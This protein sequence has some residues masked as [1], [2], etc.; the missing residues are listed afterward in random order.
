MVRT[1]GCRI[2]P[3]AIATPMPNPNSADIIWDQDGRPLSRLF[4]D[5]YFSELTPVEQ[6]RTVFLTPSELTTRWQQLLPGQAFTIAETG[7]GSGLNFLNAWQS[8]QTHAPAMATLN[9]ISAEKYPLLRHDLQRILRL[10]P[11]FSSMAEQLADQYPAVDARGF[12]RLRF[13]NVHL[14]LIFSDAVDGLG[15][16]LPISTQGPYLAAKDCGWAPYTDAPTHVDAW[17]LDGFDPL[18]NPQMWRAELF[19]IIS[20][21]SRPGT[22]IATSTASDTVALDLQ[23]VGFSAQQGLTRCGG[24]QRLFGHKLAPQ[25]SAR[26]R[27][28]SPSDTSP[29]NTFNH[30]RQA[31]PRPAPSWHLCS[32][33]LPPPKQ[34]AIIGA[35]LAG[36]QSAYA[37][38]QKGFKVTLIDKA[39]MATGA[40][41]NPQGVLYSKLSSSAGALAEFNIAALT[42]AL[43]FYKREGLFARCGDP[44]GVLQLPESA[45]K[46]EQQRSVASLFAQSPELVQWLDGANAS[47]AAG[48]TIAT[49]ALWLP[50]AGWLDPPLLC[51]TLS[52]HANIHIV[53]HRNVDRLER[54]NGQWQLTDEHGALIT[55]AEAVVIAC[56]ESARR[57]EQCSRLPIKAIRGQVSWAAA[58]DESGPL[59]AVLC[60]EGYVAPAR[61]GVHC[62]GASFNLTSRSTE[63]RWDEHHSNLNQVGKLSSAMT[64]LRVDEL[65]AGRASMR[66]TTPDYL[67]LIGPVAHQMAMGERFSVYRQNA[68][69]TVDAPGDYWPG[70]FINVGHGSKGLTY[71]PLCA[72]LLACMITNQPLPLSRKSI[73]HLHS[74]RFLIR[75]LARGRLKA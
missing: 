50:N 2:W 52:E 43:R 58:T 44:C 57:F 70:L 27:S 46:V 54:Q 24:R 41:G 21:L 67:P 59:K 68:K 6:S 36:C 31:K 28:T 22:T 34:I 14:T 69:A 64:S 20:R 33:T 10:W 39:E 23:K 74:A 63:N 40:S 37:L 16:C 71:T 26:E 55:T 11:E 42:Y 62:I 9:Y 60:G 29:P 17:F 8:W 48:V 12:H 45:A 7:F 75:D 72:E 4:N 15:Q 49:G 56:A 13:G 51:K 5:H 32:R 3:P 18:K 53:S 47:A 66:C 65:A 38:A 35:G 73:L 25:R 30:H 19:D 61:D 1:A